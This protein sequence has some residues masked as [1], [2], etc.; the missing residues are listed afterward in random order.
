MKLLP[1]S[2]DAIALICVTLI[3][4]SIFIAGLLDV[5]DYIIIKGVLFIAFGTLFVFAVSY[6]L[7][8]KRKENRLKDTLQD[9]SH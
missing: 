1:L 3:T 5:L 7:K 9:D 8:N 2:I 4:F 6:A